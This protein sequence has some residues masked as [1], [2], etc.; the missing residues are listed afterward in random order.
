M[1]HIITVVGGDK[2]KEL[3][4]TKA[5]TCKSTDQFM[6]LFQAVLTKYCMNKNFYLKLTG[7]KE[8]KRMKREFQ[9]KL[10]MYLLR[11]LILELLI[12]MDSS[13]SAIILLA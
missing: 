4:I 10:V 7:R 1:L 2:A 6:Q 13:I 12:V 5:P 9:K 11:F 8:K 3:F